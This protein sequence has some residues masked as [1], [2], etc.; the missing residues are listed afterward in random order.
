MSWRSTAKASAAAEYGRVNYE[1]FARRQRTLT[2]LA[3][4]ALAG[5][6]GSSQAA[7][8]RAPNSPSSR[9]DSGPARRIPSV[10][11]ITCLTSNAAHSHKS[12]T[13][14]YSNAGPAGGNGRPGD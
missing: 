3:W 14:A 5:A 9:P 4:L 1:R 12:L 11:L 6:I 7:I 2:L 8:S 13:D 10:N